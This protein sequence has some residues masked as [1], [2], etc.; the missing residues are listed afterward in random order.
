MAENRVFPDQSS[1]SISSRHEV[2]LSQE[3]AEEA[4]SFK[5]NLKM[6]SPFWALLQ[7]NNCNF[8]WKIREFPFLAEVKYVFE[9]YKCQIWNKL[10]NPFHLIQVLFKY[11]HIC[12][13]Y[14]EKFQKQKILAISSQFRLR[15]FAPWSFCL[16]TGIDK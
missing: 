12:Q 8:G 5:T 16:T 4:A 1:K 11:S 7:G 6:L 9:I 3:A 13:F 10:I 2:K 15:M 14:W